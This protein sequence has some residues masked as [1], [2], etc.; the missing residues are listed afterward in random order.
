[1]LIRLLRL[2][3]TEQFL[4]LLQQLDRET[5]FM[6]LEPGE[7]QETA[8]EIHRRIEQMLSRDNH[9]ILWQSTKSTCGLSSSGGGL[10]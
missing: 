8:A 10:F 1:M 2:D 6:L 7:R 4:H 5:S 9:S 3:D